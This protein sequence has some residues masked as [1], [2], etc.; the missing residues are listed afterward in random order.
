MTRDQRA[1]H[2]LIWPALALVIALGFTLA[3]TLRPPPPT[4]EPQPATKGAPQ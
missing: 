1:L 4:A 2:R 3:L